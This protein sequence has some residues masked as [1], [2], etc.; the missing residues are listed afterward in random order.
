MNNKG[1]I[2]LEYML[3]IIIIITITTITTTTIIDQN[4]QNT[5]QNA[6]QIGAQNGADKNAYAIYYNDTYN[7]Y[8]N[9]NLKLLTSNEIKIIQITT[10]KTKNNTIKIHT[11]AHTTT[12]NTNE[13]QKASARINYY[14]RKNIMQTFNKKTSN[15]YY[16]PAYSNNYQI[17]NEEIQCV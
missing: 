7:T 13:K 8:Y 5:I 10:T 16:E 6:A 2:T 4:E 12:L 17:K 9:E 1:Q 15:I 14:I 11:K 3:T